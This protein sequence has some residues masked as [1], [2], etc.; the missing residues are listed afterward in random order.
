MTLIE[1]SFQLFIFAILFQLQKKKSLWPVNQAPPLQ[2]VPIAVKENKFT[3]P[4]MVLFHFREFYI[5]WRFFSHG[6]FIHLI[7]CVY[8]N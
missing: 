1:T 7:F 5:G 3:I 4:I 6:I 8:L 2:F